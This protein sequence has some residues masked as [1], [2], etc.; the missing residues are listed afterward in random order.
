MAK[1]IMLDMVTIW[2]DIGKNKELKWNYNIG[3]VHTLVRTVLIYRPST[4]QKK[5][6]ELKNRQHHKVHDPFRLVFVATFF[7]NPFNG[8]T[9]NIK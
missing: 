7:L 2:R 3:P 9:K 8:I 6:T 5:K 1:K 4:A